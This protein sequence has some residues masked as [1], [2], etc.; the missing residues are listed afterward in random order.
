MNYKDTK[1]LKK[2]IKI[3]KRDNYECSECKRYGRITPATIVHHIKPA[4][5]Y[6]EF[7]YDSKNLYSCCAKCHNSFHDRNTNKLTSKG[8]QLID[9][10]LK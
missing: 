7:R 1:W 9:R 6:P 3:L 5:E 2:R 8:I 4:E 10:L